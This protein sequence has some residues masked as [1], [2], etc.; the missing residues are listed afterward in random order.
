MCG[1]VVVCFFFKQYTADERR[2]IYWS[3]DVC[4]S[5]LVR[6]RHFDADGVADHRTDTK[7]S[8]PSGGI[9][10]QPMAIFKDDAEP[11]VGQDFL[12]RAL[13]AEDIFLGHCRRAGSGRFEIDRG[14]LAV[15]AGF[16]FVRTEEH[17][18]ELQSLMRTSYAV[19]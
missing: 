9:G 6:G 13:E 7:A 3:S 16:Q 10:D 12:D 4:S 14:D 8:H 11:P 5:D 17:T 19:F 1:G 18:S 15:A 2:I